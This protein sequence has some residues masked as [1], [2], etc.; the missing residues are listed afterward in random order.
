MPGIETRHPRLM[1]PI[2]LR[3]HPLRNRIVFGAHTANMA[4]A[5]LPGPRL[6]AY[7]LERAL[8]G[9]AMIASPFSGVRTCASEVTSACFTTPLRIS[10]K[11]AVSFSG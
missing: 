7:L 9:A 1:S 4:D 6:G 11:G 2:R 8:G 3:G 10:V 5:G